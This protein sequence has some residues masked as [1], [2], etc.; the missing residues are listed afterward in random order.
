VEQLEKQTQRETGYQLETLQRSPSMP[1]TLMNGSIIDGIPKVDRAKMNPEE[2]SLSQS[3]I[4]QEFF[5]AEEA[6][7]I[8]SSPLSD[9]PPSLHYQHRRRG[10]R[11]PVLGAS[12]VSNGD[13]LYAPYLMRPPPLTD[14]V[15]AEQRLVLARQTTGKASTTIRRRLEIIHRFQRPKLQSDM[16][17][18]KAA[19][20]G[21]SFHDFIGWYGNPDP[22][23][24][25]GT[26]DMHE[27]LNANPTDK[28]MVKKIDKGAEAIRALEYTREFWASTWEQVPATSAEE[29]ELLFDA[30]S[31]LEMVMDYLEN[32]HPASLLSQ[33]VAV[34][35][36]MS[37]FTLAVSA[38]EAAKIKSVQATLS[39]F[40]EKVDAAL[41]LLSRDATYIDHTPDS[42]GLEMMSSVESIAACTKACEALTEAEV[43][44]ARASSLLHKLPRQYKLVESML[45]SKE[46]EL[47][48]IRLES[49]RETILNTIHEQ[50]KRLP[51]AGVIP[52]LTPAVREYLLQNVDESLP[53]QLCVRYGDAGL[54][55]C[56]VDKSGILL[57][58]RKVNSD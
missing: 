23:L 6:G 58:L 33:V 52:K 40:R 38:G 49:E 51:S 34:N 25:L 11:C 26:S 53:C 16:K 20:P 32:I 15:V 44:V 4:S 8:A 27:I 14:D 56:G 43:V 41:F 55:A 36:A 45:K 46:G 9:N 29:Q 39:R 57:A 50:Q 2:S 48:K 42:N 31:T 22:M 30:E 13:Q 21:A 12:L 17:S 1:K 10:A 28:V 18:F 47:V 35:L 24:D 54:N 3:H 37:Y 5:D 7:S 19:N